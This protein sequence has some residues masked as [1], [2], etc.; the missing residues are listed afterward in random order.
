MINSKNVPLYSTS[1]LNLQRFGL[2]VIS[3]LVLGVA[4][5]QLPSGS[6]AWSQEVATETLTGTIRIHGSETMKPLLEAWSVDF[7][8]LHPEVKFEIR[9]E[10]SL[11]AVASFAEKSSAIGAVSRPLSEKERAALAEVGVKSILEVPVARDQIAVIVHPTNPIATLNLAQLKQIFGQSNGSTG[12]KIRWNQLGIPTQTSDQ[13]IVLVGP[14]QISGTRQAFGKQVLGDSDSLAEAIETFDTQPE[15]LD[16]VAEDPNAIGFL[17]LTWL[18]PT[19]NIL[20]IAQSDSSP[21]LLPSIDLEYDPEASYPL[22]REL[23]L[24]LE[25]TD[26]KQ[27]SQADLK[28][29]EYVLSDEAILA[30]KRV[31]F[32]PLSEQ[33][34]QEARKMLQSFSQSR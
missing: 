31:R 27:P 8:R 14:N 21:A 30:V 26:Q 24:L 1:D 28:F 23:Y 25:S 29:M 12:E 9:P 4:V 7:M 15:I 11:L 33:R 18:E 6:Q 22:E 17:S 19:T 34:L 2:V 13:P 5:F 20:A 32:L 16:K 3:A 10:G